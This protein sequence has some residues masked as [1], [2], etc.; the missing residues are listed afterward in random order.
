[1]K[2]KEN[3]LIGL[4]TFLVLCLISCSSTS[5]LVNQQID[6]E[7]N[8]VNDE[9]GNAIVDELSLKDNTFSATLVL[10][11]GA[12]ITE[13]SVSWRRRV[14][15]RTGS[16][17]S[18]SSGTTL[19]IQNSRV[20][21]KDW[22]IRF[23]SSNR[24]TGN[25]QF[26]LYLEQDGNSYIWSTSNI[27]GDLENSPEFGEITLEKMGTLNLQIELDALTSLAGSSIDYELDIETELEVVSGIIPSTAQGKLI[28]N[29]T[30]IALDITLPIPVGSQDVT[31]SDI[32]VEDASEN[33]YE[34][35]S[36]TF[37]DIQILSG[38]QTEVTG[39]VT[40]I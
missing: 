9:T 10:S 31:V 20:E 22:F 7:N 23:G 6:E 28:F 17:W 24:V 33:P 30:A 3:F 14:P 4:G 39:S 1:L 2:Y 40:A 19:D 21:K 34:Y 29:D 26:A 36:I 11:D 35:E 15:I 38:E 13:S 32:E 5:T 12:N 16:S 8:E 37:E 25:Y 18:V 27:L